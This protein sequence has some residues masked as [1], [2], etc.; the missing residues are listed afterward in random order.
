M[1]S[2]R[3][4]CTAKVSDAQQKCPM[5][6][7]SVRCTA[8]VFDVQQKCPMHIKSVRC[9]NKMKISVNN[10]APNTL[11]LHHN[12]WL[13]IGNNSFASETFAPPYFLHRSKN[14]ALYR[15]LQI[16]IR[17][18]CFASHTLALH[19]KLWLCIVNFYFKDR[20]LWICIDNFGSAFENFTLHRKIWLCIGN[21]GFA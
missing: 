11:A 18:V 17:N 1:H 6:S 7:N 2:K 10:A 4:R 13:C 9:K 8:K 20:Q 14:F 21:F 3:A 19:R 5:H 12:L 15:K 16:F